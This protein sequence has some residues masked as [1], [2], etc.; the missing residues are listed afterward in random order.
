MHQKAFFL[1]WDLLYL[2]NQSALLTVLL[3]TIYLTFCLQYK[4]ARSMQIFMSHMSDKLD[5]LFLTCCTNEMKPDS[6]SYTDSDHYP[7]KKASDKALA[8]KKV[9]N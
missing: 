9:T 7:T 5:L 1:Q 4:F 3:F 6:F 8:K 2:S